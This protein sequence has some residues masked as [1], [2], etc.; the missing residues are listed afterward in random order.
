MEL[1][2]SISGKTDLKGGKDIADTGMGLK[3]TCSSDRMFMPLRNRRQ[4]H[5]LRTRPNELL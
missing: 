2:D 1:K 5:L 3:Y 4:G